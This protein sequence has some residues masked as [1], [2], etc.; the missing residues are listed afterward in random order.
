MRPYFYKTKAEW[1]FSG[2]ASGK[3]PTCR[4]MILKICGFRAGV[5]KTPWRIIWQP[6][7]VFLLGEL[8]W[9]EEP[10]GLRSVGWQRVR[11]QWSFLA[12]GRVSCL[13]PL[14]C[15]LAEMGLGPGITAS[16]LFLSEYSLPVVWEACI[17]SELV[18]RHSKWP[19]QESGSMLHFGKA[20]L[21]PQQSVVSSSNI[22]SFL[23]GTSPGSFLHHQFVSGK[24][25][26]KD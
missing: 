14:G 26:E 8:P 23:P 2:G 15:P 16:N 19:F 12:Q 3:E 22:P 11:R 7:S 4:C 21:F 20:T 18:P 9:T 6:T 10:G 5:G 1:G 24:Y 17:C 13:G 25:S